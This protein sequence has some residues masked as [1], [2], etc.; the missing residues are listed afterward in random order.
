MSHSSSLLL[1]RHVAIG[2]FAICFQC[3]RSLTKLYRLLSEKG[4]YFAMVI[5][6]SFLEERSS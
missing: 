5:Y 3:E 2:L 4:K 1:G 6:T